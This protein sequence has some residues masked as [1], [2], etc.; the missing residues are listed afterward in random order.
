MMRVGN[1]LLAGLLLCLQVWAVESYAAVLLSSDRQQITR[2]DGL[3]L[4]V[5]VTE[6]ED[7]GSVNLA[8]LHADFEI[9]NRSSNS[10]TE[11]RN[12]TTTSY[13]ELVLTVI[14]RRTGKLDIAPFVVDGSSSNGLT[15]MVSEPAARP[16]GIPEQVFIETEVDRESLYV[17]GQLIYTLRLFYGINLEDANLTDLAIADARVQLVAQNSFT[18]TINGIQFKVSEIKYAIFPQKSG[19][20]II[21]EQRLTATEL[22]GRRSLFERSRGK[23][24]NKRSTSRTIKVKPVPTQVGSDHSWLPVAALTVEESWSKDPSSLKVG[25]SATRSIILSAQGVV[26]EQIPPLTQLAPEGLKIY[27][28]QPR[29]DTNSTEFGVS[30]RRVETAAIV[31]TGPGRFEIPETSISWWNT[32]TD[33]EET[34]LVPARLIDIPVPEVAIPVPPN[35]ATEATSG[36]ADSTP[37]NDSAIRWWQAATGAALLGWL[38]TVLTW[39]LYRRQSG[40]STAIAEHQP[41]KSESAQW[42]LLCTAFDRG[43]SHAIRNELGRWAGIFYND[44]GEASIAALSRRCAVTEL[45]TQLLELEQSLYAEQNHTADLSDLLGRLKALR[46]RGSTAIEHSDEGLPPLYP[47]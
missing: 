12:G 15:I 25:E 44:P 42:K 38:L 17:Q 6:G 33:R 14:P 23:A 21:P 11:I 41:S 24:I 9:I 47:Q 4:T 18:R 7:L 37:A 39:W 31:V 3:T 8:A 28:E 1:N 29:I 46:K 13:T 34:V 43:E 2:D 5:R 16:A 35:R 30:S 45:Q 10:R 32:G 20:L 36:V 40:S 22:Q 19:D 26:G 27:P